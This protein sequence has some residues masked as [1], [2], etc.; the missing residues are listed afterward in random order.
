MEIRNIAA[1]ARRVVGG[2]PLQVAP[3]SVTSIAQGRRSTDINDGSTRLRVIRVWGI[4]ELRDNLLPKYTRRCRL[5][6]SPP[7]VPT[8]TDG[9]WSSVKAAFSR[10]A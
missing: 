10:H 9:W 1:L 8:K 6:Q 4:P 7:D 3:A 5:M 2:Q